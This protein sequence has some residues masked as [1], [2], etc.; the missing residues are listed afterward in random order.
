MAEAGDMAGL[1]LFFTAGVAAGLAS[2]PFVLSW[3]SCAS[4]LY[5]SLSAVFLV[6]CI[7]A[8]ILLLY[9]GRRTAAGLLA[10]YFAVGL[11]CAI[12]SECSSTGLHGRKS[13]FSAFAQTTA[14]RAGE[15]IDSIPFASEDTGPLVK[16]LLTGD[17]SGLDRNI[18]AA[19]RDS[20][21]AH[22]LALSGLHLGIIYMLLLW[23]FSVMGNS[24]AAKKARGIAIIF[25][26]GYYTI[27]TG[28][29]A[30]LVRAFLF[31]LLRESAKLL[32]RDIPPLRVFCTAL[33]I[34]TAIKPDVLLGVGF[35]LSYLAMAGIFLLFPHLK[36]WFPD[37]SGKWNIPGK[38]WNA[39]ALTISCQ[40]FTGPLVWFYF[41][42]FP[43]Y[44]I[45][46][47]I[48][49]IPITEALM[50]SATAATLL[51]AAGICPDF[52]VTVTDLT[53]SSLIFVMEVI[54]R[55]QNLSHI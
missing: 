26:S 37:S 27:A 20:G 24:P 30:S 13:R 50:V 5:I 33:L 17:K 19:F 16:A 43:I 14:D 7:S 48:L 38:I 54:A 11:F 28:A 53:A 51:S 47:N 1:S 3:G 32:H 36:G 10:L 6:C 44:F 52:L 40:I 25:L 18:S 23:V 2:V 55:M 12:S 15:T 35:Q 49:A 42:S 39:A 46:T 4:G 41:K 9:H 29:A 34:Q 22:I 31:I 21:A 45:L 8:L